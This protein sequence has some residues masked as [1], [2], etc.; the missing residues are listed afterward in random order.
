MKSWQMVV[1]PATTSS[2]SSISFILFT[3]TLTDSE[4]FLTV[5]LLSLDL[6]FLLEVLSLGSLVLLL[7]FSA[8][9]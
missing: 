6:S 1:D 8:K 9:I 5:L 3:P 7:L 2:F 4:R